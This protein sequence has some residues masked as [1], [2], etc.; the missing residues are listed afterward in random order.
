MQAYIT[1]CFV[2]FLC[3]N[4]YAQKHIIN[5]WILVDKCSDF[6]HNPAKYSMGYEG[7][8]IEEIL[9]VRKEKY[10]MSDE[11]EFFSDNTFKFKLSGSL[12][13]GEYK[14]EDDNLF[15]RNRNYKIIKLTENELTISVKHTIITTIFWFMNEDVLNKETA[16]ILKDSLMKFH[17]LDSLRIQLAKDEIQMKTRRDIYRK[18]DKAAYPTD[19]HLL[20]S[21]LVLHFGDRIT[22]DPNYIG[23]TMPETF[24]F[25][26][27][28]DGSISHLAT[29]IRS[30]DVYE[31]LHAVFLAKEINW[32]PAEINGHKV[33]SRVDFK[34][35]L[36]E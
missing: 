17:H 28:K 13:T 2:A 20:D 36:K 11:I 31:K 14:V 23:I 33:A 29:E 5:K 35:N 26:V 4:G 34:I 25:I 3:L 30:A 27:E 6:I 7:M 32:G 22:M 8:S 19:Q 10:Y 16:D 9:M 18:T 21:L 15:M 24:S 1:F 12:K